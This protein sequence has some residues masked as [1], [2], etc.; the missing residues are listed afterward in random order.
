M[1]KRG[2]DNEIVDD[3]INNSIRTV[4]TSDTRNNPLTGV[5]NNDPATAYYS[6]NGGYVVRND[7]TG[8]I[9]QVSDRNDPNWVAPWGD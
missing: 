2:W 9:V 1:E 3:A 7:R 5:K 6:K 8:D 4:Q